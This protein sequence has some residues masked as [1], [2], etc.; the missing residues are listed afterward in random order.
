MSACSDSAN[1]LAQSSLNKIKATPIP[2]TQPPPTPATRQRDDEE[3]P[4]PKQSPSHA[5]TRR[6]DTGSP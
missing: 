6:T 2:R 1:V 3:S 4:E 5:F